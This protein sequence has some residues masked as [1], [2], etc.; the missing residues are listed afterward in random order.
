MG[1]NG[2][3]AGDAALAGRGAHA[4]NVDRQHAEGARS[5]SVVGASGTQNRNL[6]KEQPTAC[7]PSAARPPC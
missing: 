7:Q 4:F 1:G 2:A 3:P 5:R 6:G